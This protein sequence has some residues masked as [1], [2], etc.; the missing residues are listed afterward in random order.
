M[1]GPYEFIKQPAIK[2]S[3]GEVHIFGKPFRL[4]SVSEQF[5]IVS[6]GDFPL[7][8]EEA[9][10]DFISYSLKKGI[11]VISGCRA[12]VHP[13]RLMVI[14]EDGYDTHLLDIPGPIRGDRHLYPEVFQFV[15]ALIS[16][17][18][19]IWI[20]DIVNGRQ[21]VD[22]Y[23]MPEDKLLDKSVVTENLLIRCQLETLNNG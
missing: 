20:D 4:S 23:I 14:G 7:I 15:P 8:G 16:I 3:R 11:A 18:P 19:Q 13:Y 21:A 2:A 1:I 22:M 9:L 12:R 17:P 5:R 6:H 10:T